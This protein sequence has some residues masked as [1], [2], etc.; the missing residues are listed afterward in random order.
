MLLRGGTLAPLVQGLTAL[1]NGGTITINGDVCT[2]QTSGANYAIRQKPA[3]G[4]QSL[5]R[6]ELRYGDVW[7]PDGGGKD[8]CELSGANHYPEGSTAWIAYS[9]LIP[10]GVVVNQYM[11][12]GQLHGTPGN[13]G[14]EGV[15]ILIEA[16]IDGTMRYHV[17]ASTQNPLTIQPSD[18]TAY[19]DNT[20]I[21]KGVWVNFVHNFKLDATGAT[22]FW[23]VWRNGSL[24]FNYT[25][26]IG[27]ADSFVGNYWKRGAYE[28]EAVGN[29][30][31]IVWYANMECGSADLSA[32]IATPQATPAGVAW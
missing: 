24:L 21:P 28:G 18:V 29:N 1:N 13:G 25:G 31:F 32:R 22:S 23:K 19:Q 14:L 10:V 7:L 5:E 4:A 26:A 15:P 27:I 6:Y 11:V 12:I 3:P 9:M 20:Q 2:A 17:Q 16:R 8:R 30:N